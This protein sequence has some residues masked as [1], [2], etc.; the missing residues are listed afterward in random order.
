[1]VLL[2]IMEDGTS[3][4]LSHI[5]DTES[6]C[7]VRKILDLIGDKWSL[8]VMS[9]LGEQTMRFMELRRRI[10]GIS[11]RMLTLT[12]RQLERDG[13]VQRTIYPEIPPRVEYRITPLGST[14]QASVFGI[15]SWAV[16]NRDEI[17]AARNRYDAQSNPVLQTAAD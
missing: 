4:S 7:D 5:C 14:L 9:T 17:E 1:M 11:Q 6:A 10:D 8:L 13:L 15:V 12:L 16:D 3:K 2:R